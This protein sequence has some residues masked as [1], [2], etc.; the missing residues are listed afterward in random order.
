[1]EF[2]ESLVKDAPRVPRHGQPESASLQASE[3]MAGEEQRADR[4]VLSA[5]LQSGIESRRTAKRR[6]TIIHCRSN[7]SRHGWRFE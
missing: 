3:G 1:M 5:E 4:G 7:M 2:M 6:L